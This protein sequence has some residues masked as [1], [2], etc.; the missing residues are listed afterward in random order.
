[1]ACGL[2]PYHEVKFRE[3]GIE[4]PAYLF[5]TDKNEIDSA[6]QAIK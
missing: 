4:L 6:E 5:E 1:V 3:A 2:R